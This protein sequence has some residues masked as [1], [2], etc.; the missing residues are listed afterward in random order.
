MMIDSGTKSQMTPHAKISNTNT[1]YGVSIT[2]ADDSAV[3]STQ[4]G[5][6]KV[7][8]MMDDGSQNVS[9]SE[10][11]VASMGLTLAPAMTHKDIG[12]LLMRDWLM[13][14]LRDEFNVLGYAEQDNDCLYYIRNWWWD[15]LSNY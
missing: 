13:Y 3:H 15:K 11:L 8:I 12:I 6:R 2:L 5:T 9:R 4:C 7:K 1:N 14:D 10:T